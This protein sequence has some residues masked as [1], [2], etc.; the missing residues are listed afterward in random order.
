MRKQTLQIWLRELRPAFFTASV[1]PVL[2]GTACAYAA[3]GTF[4]PLLFAL[5]LA[6][7]VCLHAGANIANDYFDH[8]SG[9]DPLNK[10]PTPFSGGSRLIQQHLLSPRAVL[11]GSI[12]F[13]IAAT[14]IGA[15]IVLLTKSIFLLALG[16]TGLLGGFFY[17]AGPLRLGYRRLGEIAIAFL[18]GVL[19]VY[20]AFYL[21]TARHNAAPL[22]PGALVAIHIFLVI[23]INEFP[24]A[25]ADAAAD[26][27]TL[28]VTLGPKP[29][30]ALYVTLLLAGYIIAAI[31][32]LLLPEMF[33]PA[34][35][36]LLTAPLA[37]AVIISLKRR[38]PAGPDSTS[39]NRLTILL[40]LATGLMLMAGFLLQR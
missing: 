11:A 18:F 20:G 27:H 2:V 30:A 1:I 23:F 33:T 19:P 3:A 12:A 10:T 40:H 32:A 24:D 25:P 38:L 35:L 28:V 29:A 21:Q 22:V 6:A 13:L 17:T 34:L 7:M 4:D 36:Y 16:I 37:V 15:V 8:L 26:K 5:A 39:P 31:A 14:A 9:N